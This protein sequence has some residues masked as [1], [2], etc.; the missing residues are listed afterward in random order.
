MKRDLEKLTVKELY[1]EMEELS[2]SLVEE[3]NSLSCA[4]LDIEELQRTILYHKKEVEKI[5]AD[6][7]KIKEILWK[8]D[9]SK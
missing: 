5:E 8:N 3:Y 7:N 6:M 2:K 9:K 4:L 1:R